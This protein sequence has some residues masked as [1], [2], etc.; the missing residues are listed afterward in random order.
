MKKLILVLAICAVGLMSQT[1]TAQVSIRANIGLQPLWG[2]VG[3]DHVDNYYLPDIETYYSVSSRMYTYRENNRWVTR[4]YLPRRN[5]GYNMYTGRKVVINGY[6]PYRRH[7]EYRVRY[8][9][10]DHRVQQ[11]IRDS[12]EPRYY[13]RRDHPLHSQYRDYQRNQ[14]NVKVQG[15]ARIA[16]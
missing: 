6:R 12:R 5:R 16:L 9:T 14:K 15:K 13:E 2:P 3:Y 11:S 8:A 7:N 10:P 1:V 4:S